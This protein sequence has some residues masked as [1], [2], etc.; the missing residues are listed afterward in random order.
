MPEN[1]ENKKPSANGRGASASGI[2][3]LIFLLI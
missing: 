2:F 1:K 3:F